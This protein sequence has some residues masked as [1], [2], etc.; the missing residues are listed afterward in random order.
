MQ[1]SAQEGE[2][3]LEYTRSAYGI[4]NL[5]ETLPAYMTQDYTLRP[6]GRKE[7]AAAGSFGSS[8]TWTAPTMLYS[9]DLQC[10]KLMPIF[11]S[12]IAETLNV[13]TVTPTTTFNITA[14]CST[15]FSHF[16]NNTIGD[17]L[18]AVVGHLI[19]LHSSGKVKT[20]SSIHYGHFSWDDRPFRETPA[21]PLC[22]YSRAEDQVMDGTFFAAFVRNKDR[23]EDPPPQTF[24]A[25]SCTPIY[26]EQDANA[27]IDSLTRIP[28]QVTRHGRKR[29]L[30]T[31]LFNVSA[32]EQTL[33]AGARTLKYR[34]D[35]LPVN[36]MP[37]Y[38]EKLSAIDVTAVQLEDSLPEL[39]P[40]SAMA[41]TSSNHSLEEFLDAAVLGQA[42]EAAYR[43]LFVRA[44]T[45][46]LKSD[47]SSKTT[48]V[49]GE[50]LERLEAV[51]LEPIFT[52]LVAGLLGLVSILMMTL[53]YMNYTSAAT[54]KGGLLLDDP[55]M[56][57]MQVMEAFLTR[58]RFDCC[59]HVNGRR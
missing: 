10:T 24:Q 3:A 20:Y 58:I 4:L 11:G 14:G 34:K 30:P 57:L 56:F 35:D 7:I 29:P 6:F 32:F 41:L 43:L 22:A 25:I 13:T 38:I 42:Y 48:G 1:V 15:G 28:T 54:L 39:P 44:M 18:A 51:I 21:F 55:G 8:G 19:P 26:Y 45:E 31:N 9:M 47:F 40:I 37:R 36:I 5:N 49:I 2:L 59:C 52:H 16:N 46:V 27:T 33:A 23:E 50:K 53:L 17:D 12:N